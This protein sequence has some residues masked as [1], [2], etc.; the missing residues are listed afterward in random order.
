VRASLPPEANV[1]PA[2]SHSANDEFLYV[3]EGVLRYRVGTDERD[4]SP[5]DW[6]FTP[7]GTVHAFSNP[8][9]QTT[10]GPLIPSRDAATHLGRILPVTLAEC[11]DEAAAAGV[12]GIAGDEFNCHAA[13]LQLL[14][15]LPQPELAK[16]LHR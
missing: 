12:T 13:G 4:L 16:H 9:K 10:L 2:H 3:L 6:M 5:G 1:P 7:R 15:R 14:H 11:F 8:Q